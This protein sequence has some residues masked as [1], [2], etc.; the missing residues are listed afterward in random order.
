MFVSRAL[1]TL[2]GL[3]DTAWVGRVSPEALAAVSA[4]FFASWSVFAVG[5]IL[6]AGITALVSQAVGA[7]R[8]ADGSRAALTSSVLALGMGAVVA[9]VGWWGAG[10]L[11]SL[12][13]D[14]PAIVRMGTDYLRLFVLLAPL[15][16]LDLC[17]ESVYR[18]CGDS[19]TPMIVLGVGTLVNLILDPLL[20]FGW[21][22]FPRLEVVGAAL[23]TICAEVVVVA[24]YAVL[25]VRRHLPLPDL[26]LSRA[27]S[28]FSREQ[29]V[30]VFRIGTPTALVGVLY[31]MVYLALSRLAGDHGAAA[32]AALGVVNRLES[33]NYLGSSAIGL[34][35]ATLVGQNHGARLVDRAESAAHRGAWL[36]TVFGG[37]FMVLFL[38]VPEWLARLF[39]DDPDAV[40]SAVMFLRIVGISQVMMAWELVYAQAF[41]GAGDTLPPMWVS[42]SMSVIR[43]PLAWWLAGPIGLGAAG[44]WW[45]ISVTGMIRGIWLTLWF[46]RG[47]WKQGGHV[48]PEH[49]ELL[50]PMRG[51]EG[52]EG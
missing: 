42:V 30:R 4:C 13:S 26:R 24:I 37:T 38:V 50:A 22:P 12:L 44:I 14:D 7:H 10:P 46:R 34:G 19:T 17:A 18:A 21:G 5:E 11:F 32:L 41:T 45:T 2:Y 40:R 51:A 36:A 28:V 43:V 49:P 1:H 48:P 6:V 52:P 16:Y 9:A 39:T 31:S 23:A 29:A 27:L 33:V 8:D 3:A 25:Y 20:I 35:V 47:A 15:F